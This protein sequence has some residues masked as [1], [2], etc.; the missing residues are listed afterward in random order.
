MAAVTVKI[1][2]TVADPCKIIL[3]LQITHGRSGVG[4]QPDAPSASLTWDGADCP[5][6]LGDTFV[7][8]AESQYDP[9]TYDSPT[10]TYDDPGALYDDD[11][12]GLLSIPRFVGVIAGLRARSAAGQVF[13]WELEGIGHLARLGTVNVLAE[14]PQE[15]DT[16]RVQA[17]CAAAGVPVRVVGNPGVQLA[18]DSVDR[19]LL[20]ALHEIAGSTGGLVWQALDGMLT[21]GT[22][23]HREVNAEPIG[24]LACEGI[25]AAL[26]WNSDVESIVNSVTVSWGPEEAPTQVTH[27]IAESIAEPWGLRHI[28][29]RTLCAAEPDAEQLALLILARRAWPYW[30]HSELVAYP[31]EVSGFDQRVLMAMDIGTPVLVPIPDDPGPT[32][33]DFETAVT[34]GWI[35]TW[36]AQGHILQLALSDQRRWVTTSLRNWGEKR[37]GGDWAHW[38]AGTWLDQLVKEGAA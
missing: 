35:E 17:L 4:T 20:A 14:R 29:V 34:E 36:A 10:V 5:W 38:A 21:Y 6:Q 37:D 28:D 1:A 22:A 18:A 23:D 13:A 31:E 15:T 12:T 27:S 25:D 9:A 16:A 19:D 11:G 30:A 26:V 33:T 7:V 3:P 2:G 8:W 32:P 24:V